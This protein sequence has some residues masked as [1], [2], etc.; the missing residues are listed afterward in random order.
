MKHPPRPELL[1]PSQVAQAIGVSEASV[2]R[3]CNKG[4]LA[5]FRTI[6]L[7]RRL[8][9]DVVIQFIRSSGRPLLRPELIGLPPATGQGQTVLPR[10]QA[11]QGGPPR[12]R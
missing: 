9:I 1:T 7:H 8:P 3:W 12:R 4:L 5:S 11:C 2:K 10:A 6:G